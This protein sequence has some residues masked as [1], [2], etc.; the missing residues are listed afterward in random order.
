MLAAAAFVGD[1]GSVEHRADGLPLAA[2]I[3]LL[4]APEELLGGVVDIDRAA[5]PARRGQAIGLPS[6]KVMAPSGQ[7]PG[8]D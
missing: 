2:A 5:R 7:S 6:G 4:L 3:L 8:Q 1:H